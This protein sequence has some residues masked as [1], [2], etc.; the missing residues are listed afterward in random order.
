MVNTDKFAP[1]RL[2]ADDENTAGGFSL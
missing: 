2:R 1:V